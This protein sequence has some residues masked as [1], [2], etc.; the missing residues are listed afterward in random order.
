MQII[1][2]IPEL[3]DDELLISYLYRI[4]MA[5]GKTNMPSNLEWFFSFKGNNFGESIENL[6]DNI[7][8]D[9]I[10]LFEKTSLFSY[11]QLLMT[12]K[13]VENTINSAF[14]RTYSNNH[15]HSYLTYGENTGSAYYCPDCLYEDNKQGKPKYIHRSHQLCGFCFKHHKKLNLVS[16]NSFFNLQ[17]P[18]EKSPL[19]LANNYESKLDRRMY[20]LFTFIESNN[21]AI[22]YEEATTIIENNFAPNHFFITQNIIQLEH[23]IDRYISSYYLDQNTY[24]SNFYLFYQENKG[25]GFSL[26]NYPII[27]FSLLAACIETP[28]DLLH[29]LP[30]YKNLIDH[31]TH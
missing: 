26:A 8:M 4:T 12:K 28:L 9:S 22:N 2:N 18:A 6:A 11:W 23:D 15:D 24:L 16:S 19:P 13:Q 21:I 20:D 14:C 10:E 31:V 29:E 25:K 27:L 5:N 30:N 1:P 17:I 3:Q 7:G